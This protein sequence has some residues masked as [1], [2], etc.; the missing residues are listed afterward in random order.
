LKFEKGCLNLGGPIGID[1]GESADLGRQSRGGD[2]P[3]PS[4]GDIRAADGI[5]PL[6]NL[7]GGHSTLADF[8]EIEI[9]VE[10]LLRD[11]HG[12]SKVGRRRLNRISAHEH[13]SCIYLPTVV[14]LRLAEGLQ[15]GL[16]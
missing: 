12:L 5:A 8:R 3:K 13:I 1:D 10:P 16:A 11:E 7:N 15:A 14:A 9:V 4:I 2:E 6:P